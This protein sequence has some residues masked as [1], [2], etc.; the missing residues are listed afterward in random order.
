MLERPADRGNDLPLVAVDHLDAADP[1]AEFD[2]AIADECGVAVENRPLQ[3]LAADDQDD[4]AVVVQ[5]ASSGFRAG[6]EPPP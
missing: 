4:D 6:N 3:D 1:V 5:A 2:G